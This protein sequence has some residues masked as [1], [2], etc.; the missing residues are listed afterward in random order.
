MLVLT[1]HLDESVVILTSDG[2]ITVTFCDRRRDGG[3]RLGIDAPAEVEIYRQE[4][5]EAI[6]AEG[7]SENKIKNKERTRED[8]Y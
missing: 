3:I 4:V 6:Q 7:G 5:Y 1:R 2:L 8:E